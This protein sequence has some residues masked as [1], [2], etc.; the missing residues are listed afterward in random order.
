MQ[1]I[2]LYFLILVI[3][4]VSG[5]QDTIYET[6]M[7]NAPVY[8]SYEDLRQSVKKTE[9]REL[10]NP[11]KIYFKDNLIFINEA[12]KGVHIFDVSNPADPQNK[13]FI[14]IPGNVDIAIRENMLY[15][16]S[17]VDLV[18]IDISN[19]SNISEKARMKDVFPYLVPE[20][21]NKYPMAEV[22]EK[23]GVVTE[24]E[25][26][27]VKQEIESR[28]YPVYYYKGTLERM[29]DYASNGAS[30][31][32]SG[33]T[34]GVGGSMA[35]FGLY[36][37][38]LYIVDEGSLYK[39]NIGNL[40]SPT[41]LGKQSIGWD[42][43]TM[44]IYND[45]MF[46]GTRTG[47]LIYNLEVASTP[48]YVNRFSHITSCDPVVVQNDLAYVTLRGG[49]VCGSNTNR[50]DVVRLSNNYTKLDLLA[51]YPMTGPYGLG[52][53]DDV[54]FVCDGDA[55]LK[56]YNASDPLTIDK[57]KLAQFP[58]I[59]TYDVIPMNNYLFMIGKDGFYLYN[60]SDLQNIRQISTIPVV[61][62]T[63]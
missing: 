35:R 6:F 46:L 7:A 44:F 1:S 31:G 43:E 55:G 30:A 25:I 8:L 52:I 9:V 10:I 58:G 16:D 54:L 11:G 36:K 19:I 59:N 40:S 56:V 12:M 29:M 49:T 42:I 4:F 41:D 51:T 15:A 34:V 17:Y 47:M 27:K 28:V 14:E 32:G 60:Y 37:N 22:D 23:K 57:H 61:K 20:Y 21:D 53:D 33:S 18:V 48:S 5:C 50:L 26:R 62:A 24:W 63:N 3:F 13:G 39:F 2:K 45:H 38:L